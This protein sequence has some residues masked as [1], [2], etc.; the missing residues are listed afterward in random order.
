VPSSLIRCG[1]GCSMR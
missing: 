1:N